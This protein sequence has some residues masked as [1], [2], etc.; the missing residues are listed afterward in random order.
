MLDA[1][2]ALEQLLERDDID[3]RNVFLFGRSLGGAVAIAIA[4][5]MQTAEA[6]DVIRRDT[7]EHVHLHR[8]HGAAKVMPLL[9]PLVGRN[10]PLHFLLRNR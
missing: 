2:A 6:A 1:R 10:H 4:E 3:R 5:R 9:G 8:G 7:G